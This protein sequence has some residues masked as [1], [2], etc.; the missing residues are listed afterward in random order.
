MK[1]FARSAFCCTFVGA[2]LLAQAHAAFAVDGEQLAGTWEYYD[3][4]AGETYRFVLNAD[5]TGTVDDEAVTYTVSGNKVRI[6]MEDEVLEY[7]V[8]LKGDTLTV[9][10]G[11]LD[12]PTPFVRKGKPPAA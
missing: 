3:A 5:G 1:R 9:S 8:A 2:L 4:A 10:G 7:A 6:K 11:D 12:G